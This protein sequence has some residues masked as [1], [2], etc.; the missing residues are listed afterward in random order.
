MSGLIYSDWSILLLKSMQPSILH[1]S[2]LSSSAQLPLLKDNFFWWL[3][4]PLGNDAS[5]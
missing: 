1:P 3:F 5:N 2:L 4:L